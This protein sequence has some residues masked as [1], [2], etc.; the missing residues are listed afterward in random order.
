MIAPIPMSSN[1]TILELLQLQ[2]ASYT[3]EAKLIGFNDIPPL[4]DS[5]ETIRRA[6]ETFIGWYENNSLL[7]AISYSVNGKVVTICRMMVHPD[8][9]R[10]GIASG[11]LQH[12]LVTQQT[13]NKFIVST[14]TLNAPAVALYERFGFHATRTRTLQ[15]N[16]SLT[17]FEKILLG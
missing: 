2:L 15:H 13:A 6:E 17:E 11:L 10:K 3:V 8:H 16:L 12:V 1:Q 7:G 4:R 9:F 14:G 5:I